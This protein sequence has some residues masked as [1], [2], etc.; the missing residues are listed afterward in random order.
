[1]QWIDSD[2]VLGDH[3]E[4]FFYVI[5]ALNGDIESDFSNRVGEFDFSLITT[6]STNFNEI[7]LPLMAPGISNAQELMSAIPGCNSVAHW[8]ANLQSYEQYIP[9]IPPTNFVVNA[10][11]PYYVNVT[12]NSDITLLGEISNPSFNLIL[13][14]TTNFNEIMLNLDKTHILK[15]SDLM[16]NIPYCNSVAYWNVAIQAYEQYI[17]GIPPTDFDVRIGYPY[18]VNVTENVT[19]PEGG[20]PKSTKTISEVTHYGEE[21]SAPHAVWGRIRFEGNNFIEKGFSFRAFIITRPE[22]KLTEKSPGC[23]IKDGYWVVQCGT[24]QSSWKAGEVL[25]IEF[26]GKDGKYKEEKEID[27]TYYPADESEEIILGGVKNLPDSYWLSQNYPNPFNPSTTIPYQIPEECHVRISIF[28][29]IGQEIRNL[30]DEKKNEGHHEVV[31][32]GR[33]RANT[34]VGSNE[35]LV[36]MV[37]GRFIKTRK[38]LFI[39]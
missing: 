12:E 23:M 19:W 35:Y 11:H 33:D 17:P 14:S 31:W 8:N 27:L 3:M 38:V 34:I 26:Q 24:F 1:V 28:N 30:V 37:A 18:Y 5:T 22:E 29:M 13:T 21:S 6:S 10:G 39:R 32:D 15:A 2:Q 36:H 9:G 16:A 7:A 4:N 20:V 25:K